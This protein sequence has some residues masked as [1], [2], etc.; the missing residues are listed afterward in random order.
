MRKPG[1]LVALIACL[2]ALAA[3]HAVAKAFVSGPRSTSLQSTA[4][5]LERSE[6]AAQP[7]GPG[8]G[9]E[10]ID[11][12]DE[13]IDGATASVLFFVVVGALVFCCLQAEVNQG[14]LG[15]PQTAYDS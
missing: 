14:V 12:E 5:R 9:P 2:A 7:G 10:E 8:P 13:G 3:L 6:R 11:F 15:N 4:I 1:R